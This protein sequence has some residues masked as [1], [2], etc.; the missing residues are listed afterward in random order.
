MITENTIYWILKLDDI[1]GLLIVMA[2]VAA[3]FSIG[4]I[5]V[6]AISAE[7]DDKYSRETAKILCVKSGIIAFICA[8][9]FTFLPNTK[10]MAM[11]KVIPAITNSEFVADMSK[12]AKELYKMGIEAIKEQLTNK[13]NGGK[14][15]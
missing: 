12:D 1:A 4:A 2:I 6:W 3:A 7:V 8:V 9:A 15:E 10:Q 11:I 5:L 13:N 14:N